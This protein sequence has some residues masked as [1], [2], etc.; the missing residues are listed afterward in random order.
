MDLGIAGKVAIVTGGSHGIGRSISDELGR[1]GVKVVVVARGQEQLDETVAAIR[2]EG[3]VA[4]AVSG[5]LT[6]LDMHD[7]VVEQ[8]V[9]AFG[10]T[11][12]IAIYSPVAPPPGPF[13]QF[14]DEDFDRSYAYVVKGFAHF[15]RAVSPG[16]KQKRWGRIITIGSGCGKWPVRSSTA[17][18]DYVLANTNRPAAL[19]LS[20]S[21]ADALG[22]FGITV[23][24]IPPGFVETGENY[25][26]WFQYCADNAGQ[27]YDEFMARLLKRIP[28]NRF[29]RPEEVGHLAA[30]LCSQSAGYI[31]GQYLVVDGGNME[32]YY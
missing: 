31:T 10:T 26:A 14:T 29:G 3:G 18:F 21:M 24:T 4:V 17:G 13:E 11:P 6:S 7:H 1:N 19:G 20:R 8:T 9:A 28:L 2:A 23:N 22:P 27:S 15:V 30:F 25:Q 32:T 12:D 5:D 16:M